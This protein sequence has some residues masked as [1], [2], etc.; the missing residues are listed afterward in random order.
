MLVALSHSH[1]SRRAA[2]WLEH[3]KLAISLSHSFTVPNQC[4]RALL[5][6]VSRVSPTMIFLPALP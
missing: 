1:L 5:A 2:K 4:T 6:I 3:T